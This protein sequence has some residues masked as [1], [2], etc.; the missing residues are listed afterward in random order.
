MNAERSKHSLL[1]QPR[2]DFPDAYVSAR[3]A[4]RLCA[5]YGDRSTA[6]PG[7]QHANM[8]T[9]QQAVMWSYAQLSKPMRRNLE[10]IYVYLQMPLLMTAVR[11]AVSGATPQAQTLLSD[12]LWNKHVIQSISALRQG[13]QS[14]MT[15]IMRI[16]GETT[17][18]T[19]K[20]SPL[21]PLNRLEKQLYEGLFR[22]FQHHHPP[23]YVRAFCSALVDLY[24]LATLGRTNAEH[25]PPEP[26]SGG[27]LTTSDFRS[28]RHMLR[29]VVRCYHSPYTITRP[30]E[31]FLHHSFSMTLKQR[32][33]E[34]DTIAQVCAY[35][36]NNM[37]YPDRGYPPNSSRGLTS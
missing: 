18:K 27:R 5:L 6:H 16:T 31:S 26:L 37:I 3:L 33:R 8:V 23:A 19:H 36:W 11:L 17:D 1:R 32:A 35:L 28:H 34:G 10:P 20:Q 21:H 12:S 13:N 22:S 4:P 7:S 25:R 9:R 14:F 2:Q 30:P 15:L 29:G 24:N